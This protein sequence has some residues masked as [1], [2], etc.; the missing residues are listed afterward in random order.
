MLEETEESMSKMI[1]VFKNNN[2]NWMSV[3]VLMG[4]KDLT[5]R[6]VLAQE[7]PSANLLI[8]LF[9]T[10]RS[11]RREITTERMGITSGQ[12]VMCFGNSAAVGIYHF[13]G[14]ISRS[15]LAFL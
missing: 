5:Q 12:R 13:R 6:G 7:F 10:F 2:P 9:H 11:F 15:I 8:C 4:D 3:H 14:K 1:T